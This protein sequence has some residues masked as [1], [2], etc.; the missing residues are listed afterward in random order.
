M[1]NILFGQTFRA[2]ARQ[3]IYFLLI[4]LDYF[5]LKFINYYSLTSAKIVAMLINLNYTGFVER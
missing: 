1:V 3:P 2:L 4:I 5:Y